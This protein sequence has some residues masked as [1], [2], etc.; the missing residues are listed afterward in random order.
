M[1]GF[2][3]RAGLACAM[4]LSLLAVQPAA[5]EWTVTVYDR[6]GANGTQLWG[7]NDAGQFVG[8]DSLG[9]YLVSGGSATPLSG[10]DGSVW[11]TPFAISNAGIVVG[12][13]VG[14]DTSEHGFLLQGGAYTSFDVDLPGVVRTELRHVSLDGQW[15]TGFYVDGSGNQSGFVFDRTLLALQTQSA[16]NTITFMQ[17]ST[18]AGL[19]VGSRSPGGG[20]I[21]DATTGQLQEVK[22]IAGFGGA[23]RFRDIN[24][25]GL[26]TG[27][28]A[29]QAIVGTLAG[30]FTALPMGGVAA[31]FGEGLNNVG[32]VVGYFTD[33]SGVT[34]GFIASSVPEPSTLI[35][36]TSGLIAL[37]LWAR[38]RGGQR[39][40]F[41]SQPSIW[42]IA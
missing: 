12:S 3:K 26:M 39:S 4:A 5:A 18:S 6:A 10:P 38:R 35:G 7:I 27:F 14:A 20:L 36:F 1:I 37:G 24:D 25:A 2:G 29:Q 40:K 42:S 28:A 34:H 21:F 13:W 11:T 16:A 33:A 19:A 15:L 17:G 31:S 9:A 22:S 30:G 41:V 8:S 23:P 32:Q